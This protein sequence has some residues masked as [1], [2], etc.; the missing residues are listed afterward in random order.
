MTTILVR[1]PPF[2]LT[3]EM[4][5]L[6]AR[7]IEEM[8]AGGDSVDSFIRIDRQFPNIS[9]YQFT[10]CAILAASLAAQPEGHA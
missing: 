4:K 10:R 5:R 3:P 9:F 7:L 1:H 8:K 6:T 2:T